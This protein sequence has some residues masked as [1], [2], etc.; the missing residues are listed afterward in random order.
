[1][2]NEKKKETTKEIF[3]INYQSHIKQNKTKITTKSEIMSQPKNEG[4]SIMWAIKN[5][6]L[7][8]V[9]ELIEQK[10]F[11][12]N[13]EITARYPIHFAA[14]YGQTDVLRYLILKG[15]NVN[16]CIQKWKENIIDNL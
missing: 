5:G 4:D 12:V 11:N 8:Q 16:V 6:D 2:T 15:A 3:N 10:Q 13:E 1:M 7:E 9:K 14:D